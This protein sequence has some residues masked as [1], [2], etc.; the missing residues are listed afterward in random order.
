MTQNIFDV[1]TTHYTK[2]TRSEKKIADF[3]FSHKETIEYLSITNFATQCSVGEATIFRFCKSLGFGGYNEF[4]LLLAKS[5][6]QYENFNASSD[7]PIDGKVNPK[8]DF[9]TLCQKL[10]NSQTSALSQTIE[11]LDEAS[12]VTS[13]KIL[14]HSKRIYCLG[15][16]SS[17]II[18]L[19]AWNR[20]TSVSPNFFHVEDSH[21]QALITSL[22]GPED[23]I[24]FF[25]Y[26]GATKGMLDILPMAQKNGTK[27]ILITH[28]AESPAAQYADTILL[29]GSNEG[30][31]QVGSVAAKV[32]QL[33]I[34]DVLFNQF[35]L[36]NSE[37]CTR[38]LGITAD[39][40]AK[41]LL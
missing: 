16:G 4:K 21:Q 39:V 38:N 36:M 28:F 7:F 15:H 34:I 23:A 24:L 26:S 10:Y 29:C 3:I 41:H 11:L 32:A 14:S 12:V 37:L 13:V 40:S 8:D 20:F 25:S 18:A 1:I 30:P 33:M 35:W 2:L 5:L 31:L 9:I 22:L 27:V 17:L 19:E 6:F